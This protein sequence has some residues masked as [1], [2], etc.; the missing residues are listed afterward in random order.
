[1][2]CQFNALISQ[3]ILPCQADTCLQLEIKMVNKCVA[4]VML[5]FKTLEHIQLLSFPIV[6]FQQIKCIKLVFFVIDFE[7]IIAYSN[8]TFACSKSTIEVLEK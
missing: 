1:M 8:Q 5:A 3:K 4:C 7:H 6:Y 2:P